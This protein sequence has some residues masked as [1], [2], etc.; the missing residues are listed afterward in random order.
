[1]AR[2]TTTSA[3]AEQQAIEADERAQERGP[4][5]VK[6][7]RVATGYVHVTNPETGVDVVFVPGERVPDWAPTSDP[8]DDGPAS[9]G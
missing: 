8:V 9:H 5:R 7:P 2:R 6:A 3:A 1:M 4:V